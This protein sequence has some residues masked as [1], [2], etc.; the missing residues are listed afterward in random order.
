MEH[1][2]FRKATKIKRNINIIDEYI[3]RFNPSNN[4]VWLQIRDHHGNMSGILDLYAHETKVSNSKE[5]IGEKH[6]NFAKYY[7]EFLEKCERD[8]KSRKKELLTEFKKL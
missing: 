1:S 2:V 8:L 7:K 4:V 5:A 3:S 6:D